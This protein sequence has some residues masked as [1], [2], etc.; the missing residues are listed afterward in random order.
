MLEGFKTVGAKIV[1][2]QFVA[3]CRYANPHVGLRIN[4]T[5]EGVFGIV[6]LADAIVKVG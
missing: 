2:F 4:A 6:V 1:E 3:L 5:G